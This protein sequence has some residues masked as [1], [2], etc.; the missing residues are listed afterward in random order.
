[1]SYS[2]LIH[3]GA[4]RQFPL[5]ADPGS[6]FAYNTAAS[7]SLGQAIENTAPLT[8]IDFSLANLFEPMGISNIE[9]L[10]TPGGLP[11]TDVVQ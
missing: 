1:M 4:V 9:I 10:R 6:E 7:V 11:D 5:A 8:L 2:N 3:R